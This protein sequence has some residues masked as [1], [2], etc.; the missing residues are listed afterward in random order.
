[1]GIGN[2]TVG[3]FLR[4]KMR[5]RRYRQT[6]IAG[7]NAGVRRI[8][9]ITA[10]IVAIGH[11]A[12]RKREHVEREHTV[13]GWF[14]G[15]SPKQVSIPASGIGQGVGSQS[16]GNITNIFNAPASDE[17]AKGR[18]AKPDD[19]KPAELPE[20]TLKSISKTSPLIVLTNISNKVAQNI[21]WQVALRNLDDSKLKSGTEPTTTSELPQPLQ[22]PA[23]TG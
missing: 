10:V 18:G 12:Y 14:N 6:Q 16:A 7:L 15:Q 13:V 17:T 8:V 5:R 22:I 23:A 9:E 1:M 20:V 4:W 3:T 2:V 19:I 11:S 21:T